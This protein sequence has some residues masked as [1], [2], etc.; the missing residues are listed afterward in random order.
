MQK[1]IIATSEVAP[2]LR[3]LISKKVSVYCSEIQNRSTFGLSISV[4]GTLEAHPE[5]EDHYRVVYSE[6]CYCYFKADDVLTIVR[7]EE[8]THIF[9]DGSVAVIRIDIQSKT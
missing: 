7:P 6:G 5:T 2:L 1:A 3:A 9:R 8:G 4:A